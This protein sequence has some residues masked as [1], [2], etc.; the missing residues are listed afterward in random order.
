MALLPVRP[1]TIKKAAKIWGTS[2]YKAEKLL[3]QDVYKRQPQYITKARS[4]MGKHCT[5]CSGLITWCTGILRGSANY[6]ETAREVQPIGALN[7][8]MAGW[9][10]WKLSLIHI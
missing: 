1:F 10:L 2:E 4:F 9:A 5:D 7:E 6:K 3:D 8:S